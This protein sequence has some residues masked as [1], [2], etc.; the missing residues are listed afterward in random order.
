MAAIKEV[1]AVGE[2]ERLEWIDGRKLVADGLTKVVG[3]EGPL[4]EFIRLEV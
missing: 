4:V 1:I 2:V 3:R